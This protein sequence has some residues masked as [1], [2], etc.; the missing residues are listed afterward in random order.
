[1]RTGCT[2]SVYMLYSEEAA[3]HCLSLSLLS[4]LLSSLTPEN[5]PL[6]PL[7]AGLSTLGGVQSHGGRRG[8]DGEE[9][10]DWSLLP[11][12]PLSSS[13]R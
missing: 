2:Y 12:S 4:A 5:C 3:V 10:V 8:A 1:V 6:S 13:L 9:A 7:C 11:L